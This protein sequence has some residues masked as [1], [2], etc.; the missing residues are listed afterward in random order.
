LDARTLRVNRTLFRGEVSQPKTKSSRRTL[1]LSRLAVGA[2][3]GWG[4]DLCPFAFWVRP[5]Y[6][7]A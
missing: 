3:G 1:K 4:V 7:S 2:L 6:A 5:V